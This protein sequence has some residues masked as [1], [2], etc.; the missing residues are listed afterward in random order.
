MKRVFI[1]IPFVL[2][3]LLA[4]C[5]G[6]KSPTGQ[7]VGG[8]SCTDSDDGV[9]VRT[10]GKVSGVLES[11]EAYE[12]ED[13]CLNDIVVEYYC[14]DNKPVNRNHRCSSDCKEGACVNPLAGE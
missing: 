3:I 2:L 9:L 6:S 1:A 12:K 13:F 11:G 8:P 5:S 14:E 4:G 7:V 10:H